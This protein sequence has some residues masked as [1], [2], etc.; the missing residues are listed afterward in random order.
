MSIIRLLILTLIAGAASSVANEN[1][2]SETNYD[3]PCVGTP[4][5]K[6]MVYLNWGGKQL[7]YWRTN[8]TEIH[9]IILP[10]DFTVGL[11]IED[12]PDEIYQ[13]SFKAWGGVSDE[14][15]QITL[16]DMNSKEPKYLTHTY[17]G[18]NS[19][20]GYSEAGGATG[21]AELGMPGITL[22]LMKPVCVTMDDIADK[23]TVRTE[24]RHGSALI[25]N[26]VLEIQEGVPANIRVTGENSYEL[27]IMVSESSAGT[28]KI[29]AD[30][31][32]AQGEVNP[33]IVA[34]VG[35]PVTTAVGDLR[36]TFTVDAE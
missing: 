26:P 36:L 21:V 35:L 13:R 8:P 31:S 15:V 6:Q 28:V 22:H 11:K 20:Q 7:D 32:S 34:E 3:F 2:S 33:V 29:A 9:S 4:E 30:Y 27:T 1:S 23:F 14:L 19:I 18:A 25:A 16:Y 12:A 5:R 17:G 24:V 10:N